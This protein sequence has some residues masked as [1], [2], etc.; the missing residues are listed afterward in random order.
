[1]TFQYPALL[2][3]GDATP[4]DAKTAYGIA[5]WRKEDC[6]GQFALPGATANLGLADLTPEVAKLRGAQSMILGIANEGGFIPDPWL[7]TLHQALEAGLDLVAGLHDRLNDNPALVDHARQVGQELIDVRYPS[8]KIPTG[9]G[10]KRSGKRLLTV[11][12]DCAVGKMY[13]SLAIDRALKANGVDSDFVA[14]GQTGIFI[15]GR[16]ISV[17]AVVSDFVSGAAE[18][19]SPDNNPMH[20]DIIEGQGSLVHPAYAAV[21]LGLVHGS[22]P[23]AMV[24][25]HDAAR[26]HLDGYPDRPITAL[27]LLIDMYEQAAWVNNPRARVIGVSLNTSRM[28]DGQARDMLNDLSKDLGLPCVD[29]VRT[30]VESLI[31]SHDW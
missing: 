16:G 5:H 19:L 26:T 14:T 13:T 17:D 28:E 18:T 30:G 7:P 4:L 15:A 8:E 22:Q 2:F 25:C 31:A 27:P 10:H 20:W 6:V 23:D 12:T 29:P 11:G 1:M 9:N 3:L 24:L 21:T